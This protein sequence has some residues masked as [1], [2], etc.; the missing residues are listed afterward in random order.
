MDEDM[1][2]HLIAEASF[3]NAYRRGELTKAEKWWK[4]LTF[5]ETHNS[6]SRIRVEAGLAWARQQRNCAFDKID[7]GLQLLHT[8]P[9][10]TERERLIEAWNKWREEMAD[11]SLAVVEQV[12]V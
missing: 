10:T 6:L 7:E 1:R 9:A 3:F 12:V 8:L 4:Q 11:R 5:P 2:D